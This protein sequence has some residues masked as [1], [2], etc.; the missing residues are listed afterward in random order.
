MHKKRDLIF[1]LFVFFAS[2]SASDELALI[3]TNDAMVPTGTAEE[4][5][6][7]SLS[8]TDKLAVLSA[9][10]ASEPITISLAYSSMRKGKQRHEIT[11]P[12]GTIILNGSCLAIGNPETNVTMRS[13]SDNRYV[14]VESGQKSVQVFSKSPETDAFTHSLTFPARIAS[15]DDGKR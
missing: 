8:P 9:L 1:V 7:H 4:E 3:T 15:E 10:K 12:K 13:S 2:L 14:F 5:A 11:T 6:H